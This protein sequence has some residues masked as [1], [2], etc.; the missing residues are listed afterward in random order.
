MIK[1]PLSLVSTRSPDLSEERVAVSLLSA[2]EKGLA[3]D[4]GLYIPKKVPRINWAAVSN[5]SFHSC[6]VSFL[7]QW[8]GGALSTKK[9]VEL[10]EQALNFEV[11]LKPLI[12]TSLKGQEGVKSFQ[13]QIHVLE[14]RFR[15]KTLAREPWLFCWGSASEKRGKA[16]PF[17]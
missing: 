1:S 8:L 2:V 9:V 13:E 5:S 17:L 7:E 12:P 15:S 10:V 14:Q 6:S 3:E 4:G 11:P 16:S